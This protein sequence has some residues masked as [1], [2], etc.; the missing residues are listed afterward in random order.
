MQ[1]LCDPAFKLRAALVKNDIVIGNV[2]V[3]RC[4]DLR[5]K[6]PPFVCRAHNLLHSKRFDARMS[7]RLSE[8]DDS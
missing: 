6:N 3:N 5:R 7:D 8:I 1:S 4:P 2:K